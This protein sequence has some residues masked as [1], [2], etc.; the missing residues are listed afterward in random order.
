MG[1]NQGQST[2]IFCVSIGDSASSSACLSFGVPQGQVL[3]PLLFQFIYCHLVPFFVSMVFLSIAMHMT[4]LK[5]NDYR[6]YS[7]VSMT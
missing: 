6:D 3:G 4:P 2:G 1:G 7:S 5:K